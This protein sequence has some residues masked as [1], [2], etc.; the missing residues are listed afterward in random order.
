MAEKQNL[1][2]VKQELSDT[3]QRYQRYADNPEEAPDFEDFENLKEAQSYYTSYVK[4]LK[5]TLDTVNFF[6]DSNDLD[7]FNEAVLGLHKQHDANSNDAYKDF[8]STQCYEYEG[9]GRALDI[10][11]RNLKKKL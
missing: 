10:I 8:Y 1:T 2:S 9:L 4:G 11:S 5:N 6:I 7:A 3:I